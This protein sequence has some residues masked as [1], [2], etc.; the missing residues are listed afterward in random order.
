MD[1]GQPFLPVTLCSALQS[2]RQLDTCLH[3]YVCGY[4]RALLSS[5]GWAVRLSRDHV[6]EEFM[7]PSSY[8][9]SCSGDNVMLGAESNLAQACQVVLVKVN[10]TDNGLLGSGFA[11]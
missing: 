4:D 3:V 8:C 7:Q 2:F 6:T 5:A 11:T 9:V 10:E 1:T